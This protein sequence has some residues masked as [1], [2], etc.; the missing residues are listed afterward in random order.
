MS[1]T[2]ITIT[3]SPDYVTRAVRND[4]LVGTTDSYGPEGRL[5]NSDRYVAFIVYGT[6]DSRYAEELDIDVARRLGD[7]GRDLVAEIAEAQATAGYE[8]GWTEILVDGPKIG[9]YF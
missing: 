1:T 9:L 7:R 2:D 6:G 3:T 8:A 5:P 4:L